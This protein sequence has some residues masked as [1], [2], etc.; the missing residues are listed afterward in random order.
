MDNN[1]ICHYCDTDSGSSGASILNM[2]NHKI[3]GIYLG[4]HSKFNFNCGTLI[5]LPI[6][7]YIKKFNIEKN[8]IYTHNNYNNNNTYNNYNNQINNKKIKIIIIFLKLYQ[9]QKMVRILIIYGME[10][11]ISEKFHVMVMFVMV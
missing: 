10:V 2:N 3:I 4:K 6:N 1:I 7:E 11:M 5:K 9:K 8:N